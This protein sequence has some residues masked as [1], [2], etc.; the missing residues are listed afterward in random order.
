[1]TEGVKNITKHSWG[2]Q[3]VNQSGL[4]INESNVGARIEYILGVCKDQDTKR[5][6]IEANDA[7][8]EVSFAKLFQVNERFK[9][10]GSN[11][12]KLAIVAPNLVET[13]MAK[14]IEEV[15]NIK[16]DTFLYFTNKGEAIEWL[17]K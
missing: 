11:E 10:L 1:M 4:Q 13:E 14:F 8:L 7:T 5:I 17:K 3:I 9:Q 6:L 12:I 16:G 15:S 2:I